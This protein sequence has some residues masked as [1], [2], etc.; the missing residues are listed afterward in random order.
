M[1]VP[2]KSVEEF[3]AWTNQLDGQLL[4]YRG[5]G[6]ADWEVESSAQRRIRVS[7][8]EPPPVTFQNYIEQ[9]LD[10]SGLQGF[11]YQHDRKLSDLEL[12][13]ELQHYGAAT[14]LIDFTENS[15]IALWFACRE[16]LKK[17][18]KVAAMATDNTKSFPTVS[19]EDLNKPIMHFLNKGKL[20]KWTPSSLN[21]RIVSQQSVF[22]FG[23]GMIEE[24][25]Y[26]EIKIDRGSKKD[27]RDTLEKS[28]GVKEKHLFNDLSGFALYNAH[29]KPYGDFKAEDYF[30]WGVT[31]QQ[32]G[33]REKAKNYYTKTLEL[34][35]RFAAAYNNRGIAK[36]NLDDH[37][38]AIADF[39]KALKINPQYAGAYNNR[40]N[41]KDTLGDHQGAIAD[42]DKALELDPQHS[43][44]YN[45]RGVAKRALGDHQGA[46]ED[47][48]KAIVSNP[49]DAKAYNNRGVA[50]RALGDHQGALVDYNKAIERNPQSADAYNNRGVAKGALGDNH[51]AISDYDKVLEVNPQYAKAYYNR[52]LAKSI[53]GDHQ[54]AIEDYDKVIER[55][56]KYA[57]AY[58]NRGSV[59]SDLGDHQGAIGDYD[60]TLELNPQHA[61]AYN[62]RGVA[63]HQ[64]GDYQGAI[65]D[66]DYAL[67]ID[68][69]YAHTYKYRGLAKQ[70]LGDQAGA[71]GDFSRAREVD[72]NI[73]MPG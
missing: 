7:E 41:A 35:R 39:D 55:N 57:D 29:D 66:Y 72:P 2:I 58:N 68:P 71:R 16:E 34:D 49:H 65:A 21:N 37:Q 15:L 26:E 53:L 20:W 32:Q 11:R 73:E 23:E 67:A 51:G 19:Y 43:D 50:K 10:T 70:A 9:L 63:K 24:N 47:Y 25:L 54:G 45:N 40:G 22:V 18:G 56:P 4:L 60:K 28:F 59:K 48:D 5:L 44:A 8:E 12:L 62:N 1:T 61:G 6:D 42:F 30:Y 52:G 69:Q 27:I 13:A 17:D 36:S 33:E 31:F 64:L 14:C 3:I 38:G 46:I